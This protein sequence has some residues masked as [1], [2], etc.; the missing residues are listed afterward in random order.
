MALR[1]RMSGRSRVTW[2]VFETAGA[3]EGGV[4]H[5]GT[6]GG[7]DDNDM[8][9]GFQ[10]PSISTKSWFRVCSRSSWPPPRPA[11]R[12]RP[13]ASISSTK[14]IQGEFFL[15]ASNK[16]R[17][18]TGTHPYEHLDELGST[19]GE[20]GNPGFTGDGFAEKSLAGTGGADQ[21]DTL[22]EASAD[23]GESGGELQKL[24]DFGEFLSG[25]HQHR[26]RWRT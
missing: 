14:T 4:E 16:S 11:P 13:T 6:V 21:E 7:G 17:T 23:I 25:L 2:T 9:A 1:P 26:R 19:D 24:D 8:G 5:I 12:W 22:R 18:P 20:E 3:K 10:K 15:A